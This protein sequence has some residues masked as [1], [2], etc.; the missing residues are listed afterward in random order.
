ME[1]GRMLVL[2]PST[3]PSLNYHEANG[4]A[5]HDNVGVMV[6]LLDS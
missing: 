2:S 5:E 1:V 3:Y 6:V 4:Y